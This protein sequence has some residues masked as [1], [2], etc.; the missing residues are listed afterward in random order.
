MRGDGGLGEGLGSSGGERLDAGC[1]ILWAVW[2]E[3][4]DEFDVGVRR[5]ENQNF[6]MIKWENNWLHQNCLFTSL[7]PLPDHKQ[8]PVNTRSSVLSHCVDNFQQTTVI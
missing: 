3:L 4:A 5:I 6:G 7:S 1:L 8:H 2:I